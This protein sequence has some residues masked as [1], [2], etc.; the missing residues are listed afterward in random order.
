[1]NQR[2]E[3]AAFRFISKAR[4]RGHYDLSCEIQPGAHP[5]VTGP[6]VVDYAAGRKFDQHTWNAALNTPG[7]G[8]REP[9]TPE[10]L[11]RI[12]QGA[13]ASNQTPQELQDMIRV[14]LQGLQS[15]F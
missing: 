5:F 7:T 11:L 9:V 8:L 14:T 13:L 6:T 15:P 12:Q 2:R 3:V 1:M 10:L 4:R